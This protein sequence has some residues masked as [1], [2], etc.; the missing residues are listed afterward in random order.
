MDL[1]GQFQETVEFHAKNI[2][3]E[4]H[5][6]G[7]RIQK[8]DYQ[9]GPD[10]SVSLHGI[11]FRFV[12]DYDT[13]SPKE[14][15][16]AVEKSSAEMRS[17]NAVMRAISSRSSD[18]P[19]L[20]FFTPFFAIVDYKGFR[21]TA[22]AE[23]DNPK[24]IKAVHDLNPRKL[25][26]DET[27]TS[28]TVA[29]SNYLNLKSHTVQVHDDRRVKVCLSATV[30]I[31]YDAQSGNYFLECLR[32]IFPIDSSE[33]KKS[34]TCR[35]RPEFLTLYQTQLCADGLTPMAGASLREKQVND[36]ELLV[37]ARFMRE[38]WIPAFIKSL[39]NMEICPYDSQ[40]L[41]KEMHNKGINMRYL[42]FISNN[43]TIPFISNL[44]LVE[45]VARVCKHLYQAKLRNAILHFRSVGATSIEEQ[46]NIYATNLM[47]TILGYNEKTETFVLSK[48][49]PEMKQRFNYVLGRRQYFEIPRPAL[50]LAVQYHVF[51]L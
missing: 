27:A 48:L 22:H 51:F 6:A 3:D 45:M 11:K 17:L 37:A 35:F 50:L 19:T 1:V 23:M 25:L 34:T 9:F 40:S 26:I 31:H 16:T 32:D 13:A 12:C 30:E 18:V 47:N 46:M 44:A 2:I 14:I 4:Y 7:K 43:S 41:T 42:G 38:N 29:I 20:P 10:G 33:F 24:H 36:D 28:A 8:Y 49:K 21:I 5:I 15:E 39:D